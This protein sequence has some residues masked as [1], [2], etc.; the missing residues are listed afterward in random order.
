LGF[1]AY[2]VTRGHI[3]AGD[4]VLVLG[5]VAQVYAP[6]TAISTTVAGIQDA[7]ISVRSAFDLLD[8][9]PAIRD[10]PGAAD[11]PG[12]ARGRVEFEGVHFSHG[13][14]RR[15]TLSGVSF[16]AEP[17]QVVAVVGPTG[18]GKSTLVGLI[19][20]FHDPGRGR[21]LLDGRDA[22][23][24]TLRSL[25]AQVAVVPLEPLLFSGTVADNVRYGRPGASDAEV[26]AAARAADAHDFIER[27]PDKY[28][29]VVGERGAR[30]SGGER[31]RVAV[32]R[33]FLRD[34]PVLILDEPTSAVD[35]R[36]EA[37]ILD[38]L[39][40]LMAGRTTFMIAHRLS[41]VRRA[42]LIL[43]LDRGRLVERGTHAELLAAGGLYRQRHDIQHAGGGGRPRGRRG[44]A[45]G[46]PVESPATAVP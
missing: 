4:L 24:L 45:A 32:A 28:D 40:R 41:T 20:R 7:L 30:L 22:R 42:D 5:Y 33:A 6:L 19:P 16:R 37:A 21:V 12:R 8:T 38:A 39:D 29:T 27:L 25:R 15:E 46:E 43:V 11:L 35:S 9:E 18:A 10:A 31:Q 2:R 36:T 3:T 14:R 23:G 17:G 26:V 34:A 13:G 1:G 44:A